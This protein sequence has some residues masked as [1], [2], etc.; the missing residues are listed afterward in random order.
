VN[1]RPAYFLMRFFH[2]VVSYFHHGLS[3]RLALS[4]RHAVHMSDGKTPS[5]L[6]FRTDHPRAGTS[7]D[8][9]VWFMSDVYP[10][11]WSVVHRTPSGDAPIEGADPLQGLREELLQR[12]SQDAI[13]LNNI[14]NSDT[15]DHFMT[16]GVAGLVASIGVLALTRGSS[17]GLATG[18]SLAAGGAAAS[19]FGVVGSLI[20]GS[21]ANSIQSDE[22]RN[23]SELTAIA[24]HYAFLQQNSA[25]QPLS[26]FARP[27]TYELPV[28]RIGLHPI[29]PPPNQ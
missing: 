26:R 22:A 5:W 4:F 21:K 14:N 16:G 8:S 23:R 17:L 13:N 18:I 28:N 1:V 20:E 9:G 19:V 24:Q 15:F 27:T 29:A 25:P 6:L 12:Q 2:F 3:Y 7:L 10:N 11:L